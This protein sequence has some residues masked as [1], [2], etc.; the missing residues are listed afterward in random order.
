ML[1]LES[2]FAYEFRLVDSISKYGIYYSC[3]LEKNQN[4]Q[5]GKAGGNDAVIMGKRGVSEHIPEIGRR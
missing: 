1:F 2:Y 5:E 4:H 3:F